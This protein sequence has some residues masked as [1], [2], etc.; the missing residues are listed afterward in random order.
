LMQIDK[1]N[2]QSYLLKYCMKVFKS[3]TDV[4]RYS[5]LE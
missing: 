2:K 1:E 4:I 3:T 5:S